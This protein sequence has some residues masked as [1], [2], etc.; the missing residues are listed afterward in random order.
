[1]MGILDFIWSY[2]GF[3][4]CSRCCNIPELISPFY[5][6]LTRVQ[7][8]DCVKKLIP[9]LMRNKNE[10]GCLWDFSCRWKSR[11]PRVARQPY[12]THNI[13][14]CGM[15]LED[16]RFTVHRERLWECRIT[17]RCEI[18]KRH[19]SCL[20]SEQCAARLRVLSLCQDFNRQS[21]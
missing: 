20:N 7:L 8:W 6:V 11:C 9:S 19:L 12:I 10:S 15:A 13:K 1:M 18:C 3:I 16:K 17:G 2:C 5:K 21:W 14:Q 4:S